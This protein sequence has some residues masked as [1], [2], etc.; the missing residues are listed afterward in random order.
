M[1]LLQ[2]IYKY[3]ADF[4]DMGKTLARGVLVNIGDKLLINMI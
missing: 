4:T 3:K 2:G 1:Q